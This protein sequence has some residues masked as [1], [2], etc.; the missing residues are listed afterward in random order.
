[1]HGNSS[2]LQWGAAGTDLKANIDLT[3]SVNQAGMP[4]LLG[5]T[6]PTSA[7]PLLPEAKPCWAETEVVGKHGFDGASGVHPWS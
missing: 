6:A 2:G 5:N 3:I 7:M 4:D 1:M